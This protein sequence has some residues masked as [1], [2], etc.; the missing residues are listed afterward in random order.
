L[1]NRD[2]YNRVWLSTSCRRGKRQ[3]RDTETKG[4]LGGVCL[5]DVGL[6]KDYI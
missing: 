3:W 6:R 5:L 2:P 1:G 4:G